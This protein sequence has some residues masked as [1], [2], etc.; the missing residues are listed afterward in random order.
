MDDYPNT[1]NEVNVSPDSAAEEE[2]IFDATVITEEMGDAFL[3]A[4]PAR[5]RN[6]SSLEYFRTAIDLRSRIVNLSQSQAIPKSL[7][8]AFSVPMCNTA[9]DMVNYL[10]E[11]DHYFPNTEEHVQLRKDYYA[12]AEACVD[13]LSQDLLTLFEH[14]RKYRITKVKVKSILEI[15]QLC[16]Q[17]TKLL[18]GVRK[19]VKKR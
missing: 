18:K 14:Q 6:L 19:N 10:V 3:M 15:L 17:E 16:D 8:S 7:R 9:R 13:M 4:V 1:E 5:L 2:G 11:A 12:K